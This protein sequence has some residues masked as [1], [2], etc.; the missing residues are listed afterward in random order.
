MLSGYEAFLE[1][2][3]YKKRSV[4]E[5]YQYIR[6]RYVNIYGCKYTYAYIYVYVNI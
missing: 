3:V 5:N 6:R 1:E 2:Y 4:K